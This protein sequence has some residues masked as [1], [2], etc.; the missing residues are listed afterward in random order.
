MPV[1]ELVQGVTHRIFN[2]FLADPETP[3]EQPANALAMPLLEHPRETDEI[4]GR[5]AMD[6]LVRSIFGR[7]VVVPVVL[8]VVQAGDRPFGLSPG[9]AVAP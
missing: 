4:T 3:Q 2:V 8:P 7:G 5:P 1:E 9:V 6:G